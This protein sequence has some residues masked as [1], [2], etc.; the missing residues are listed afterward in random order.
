[1]KKKIKTAAAVLLMLFLLAVPVRAQTG[2]GEYLADISGQ[3]GE[4]LDSDERESY[5]DLIGNFDEPVTPS[6]V[7]GRLWNFL[8][9]GGKQPLSLCSRLMAILLLTAVFSAYAQDSEM[10][11]SVEF[12]SACVQ[13]L[14][15]SVGLFGLIEDGMNALQKGNALVGTLL[16]VLAGML[17]AAG[18]TATSA[19]AYGG[20]IA[21][22]S[23]LCG[24]LSFFTVPLMN[25]YFSLGLCAAL[26]RETQAQRLAEAVK[27]ITVWGLTLLFT[28]FSGVLLL[29]TNLVRAGE[30]VGVK[31]LKYLLGSTV[32]VTG[33]VLSES[34]TAVLGS[35]SLLRHTAAMYGIAAVGVVFLPVVLELLLFKGMLFVLSFFS[36]LFGNHRLDECFGVLGTML[37][38]LLSLLL[39]SFALFILSLGVLMSL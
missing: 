28:V 18:K 7:M 25:A 5:S 12:L 22:I 6:G 10:Q 26:S 4:S 15:L 11:K 29:K 16:P 36:G 35:L 2:D 23:T 17:S 3:I 1:M 39:F 14:T 9:T 34:L 13:M 31:T 30:E 20:I 19:F 32:P 21:A 37:S 38:L 33:T 8:K 27:K 24:A